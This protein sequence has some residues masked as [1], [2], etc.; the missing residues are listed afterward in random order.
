MEDKVRVRI[1]RRKD[2]ASN[3]YWEEFLVPRGRNMNVITLLMEIQKNPVNTDNETTTPVTW[4]CNCLEEVCGACSMVINGVPRQ[5]CS[6]LVDSLK[7]PITL[8]P[9]SKFP[10]IR[11]LVVDR[12]IMFENLKKVRA[13][14]SIDGSYDLGR[15]PKLSR[16]DVATGY[17][18]SRCMT[19]GCCMEICPQVNERTN[20][21]GAAAIAQA[22]LFN[23][24]PTGKMMKEERI[25]ALMEDG[26]INE[27]G[28]A[29]N[30]ERV[31]PKE[32]PLLSSIA[33]MNRE[34]IKHFLGVILRS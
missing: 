20:F 5:A 10:V 32:I 14:I 13:W 4:E 21:I 17:R 33:E 27:C 7:S 30:C 2:A 1:L 12:A 26:G 25:E 31:C 28:N 8:K 22:R 3:E 11:D 9:L 23:I 19:C 24:H 16:K 29:Q 15:G 6:A 18:L 34:A